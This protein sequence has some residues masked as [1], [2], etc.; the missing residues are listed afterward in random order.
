MF[1]PFNVYA[2]IKSENDKKGQGKG[3]RLTS[4]G[5]IEKPGDSLISENHTG[6]PV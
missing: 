2:P 5:S 1:D 3:S 6:N 4:R